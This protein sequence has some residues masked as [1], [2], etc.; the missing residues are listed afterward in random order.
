MDPGSLKIYRNG[1]RLL[2]GLDFTISDF[3]PTRQFTFTN[4][5]VPDQLADDEIIVIDYDM[6][7]VAP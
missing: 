5:Q 3:A 1:L 7:N 6:F 4:I 2:A